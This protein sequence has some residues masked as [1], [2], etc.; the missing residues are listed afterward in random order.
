[1]VTRSTQKREDNENNGCC[2][3]ECTGQFVH[4]AR[5]K[6]RAVVVSNSTH[7]TRA[8]RLNPGKGGHSYMKGTGMLIGKIRIRPLKESNLGVAQTLF[9]L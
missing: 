9:D 2:K 5:F 7:S 6:H 8:G 4:S 3:T 1:M